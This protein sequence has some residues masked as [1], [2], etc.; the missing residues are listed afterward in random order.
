MT[1]ARIINIKINVLNKL[2]LHELSVSHKN[3]KS[4]ANLELLIKIKFD[5]QMGTLAQVDSVIPNHVRAF[6]V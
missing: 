1:R 6:L 5:L 3:R 2:V 4:P